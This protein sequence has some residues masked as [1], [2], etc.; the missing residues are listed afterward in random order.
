MF[1]ALYIFMKDISL[2]KLCV[3]VCVCTHAVISVHNSLISVHMIFLMNN[4]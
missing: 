2:T 4:D 3:C 1:Y